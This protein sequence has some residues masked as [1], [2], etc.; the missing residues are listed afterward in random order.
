MGGLFEVPPQCLELSCFKH[1]GAAS[2]AVSSGAAEL[3]GE[4]IQNTEL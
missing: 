1:L 4:L 3:A 2:T